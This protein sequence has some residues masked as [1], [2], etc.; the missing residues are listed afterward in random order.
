MSKNEYMLN[1]IDSLLEDLNGN[2][3]EC[4][5]QPENEAEEKLFVRIANFWA[6]LVNVLLK[7]GC[8]REKEYVYAKLYAFYNATKGW[9]CDAYIWEK[10]ANSFIPRITVGCY[11][12]VS[13]F[14][15]FLEDYR[16]GRI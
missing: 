14:M 15:S 4:V 12:L 13:N 1:L 10:T 5:P 3:M 16:D 11:N 6:G 7:G 2:I 9:Y 8:D